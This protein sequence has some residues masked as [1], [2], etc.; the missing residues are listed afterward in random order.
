MQA[1]VGRG[2]MT[3]GQDQARSMGYRPGGDL[4]MNKQSPFG[5]VVTCGRSRAD[6]A[7]YRPAARFATG[8]SIAGAA[9][10]CPTFCIN[11]SAEYGFGR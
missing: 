8:T 9:R 6:A 2:G 7:S 11:D 5:R 1:I 10:T 4:A 3:L